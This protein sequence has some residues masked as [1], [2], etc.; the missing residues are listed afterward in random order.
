MYKNI[1]GL[2][3]KHSK[4]LMM[5]RLLLMSLIVCAASV[6]SAQKSYIPGPAPS[7]IGLPTS[8]GPSTARIFNADF[9]G[10]G[11]QDLLYQQGNTS[12]LGIHYAKNNN[13]GT[14]TD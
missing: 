3:S 12:G 11:D 1:Q 6:V 10:D 13:N 4:Q 8:L 2:I 9:D 7:T 5:I 14:F